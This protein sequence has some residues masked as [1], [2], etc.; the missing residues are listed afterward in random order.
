MDVMSGH[1][2]QTDGF[3]VVRSSGEFRVVAQKHIPAGGRLFAVEGEQTKVPTR[4]SVQVDA[5]VHLDLPEGHA[6]EELMDLFYWRFTNHSCSPNAHLCGRVFRALRSIEPWQEIT[7]N[8]NTTEYEM[9]EPFGCH[10]GTDRC[11]GQVRGFRFLS[12]D[13]RE[14]LRPWLAHHLLSRLEGET[15]VVHG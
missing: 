10:C 3:A 15:S 1:I 9:A 6:S 12:D 5:T 13:E 7:F 8:Y 2:V 14:Q 4:F 11:A